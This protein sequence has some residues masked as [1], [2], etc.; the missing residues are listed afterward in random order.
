MFLMQLSSQCLEVVGVPLPLH[1]P[2]TLFLSQLLPQCLALPLG[3]FKI[4]PGTAYSY[5]VKTRDT[6]AN[7]NESMASAP[8]PAH[9]HDG[10]ELPDDW[11]LRY[12]SDLS[13]RP[14]DDSDQDGFIDLYEYYAGTNPTDPASLLIASD[15]VMASPS[16]ITLS[17]QSTSNQTYTIS[18]RSDLF[19]DSWTTVRGGIAATPPMN[20]LTIPVTKAPA[21]YRIGLERP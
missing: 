7:V 21:Y 11:E 1:L 6:S 16:E 12:F 8:V 20:T 10:D 5:T 14:Q 3:L 15:P 9:T 4:T 18:C 2:F 17:W 19:T 13:S